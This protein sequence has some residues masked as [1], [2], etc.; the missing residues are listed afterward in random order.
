MSIITAKLNKFMRGVRRADS[1]FENV[2][3]NVIKMSKMTNRKGRKVF[4]KDAKGFSLRS[5]RHFSAF[6]AVWII[7]DL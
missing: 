6:S 4:A 1:R 7:S 2:G 5:L 3:K